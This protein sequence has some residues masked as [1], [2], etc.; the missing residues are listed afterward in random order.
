MFAHTLILSALLL[1]AF[2]P[3]TRKTELA[4]KGVKAGEVQSE[5]PHTVDT[6]S[7][8]G[9]RLGM[10]EGEVRKVVG[11]VD[12]VKKGGLRKAKLV[13]PFQESHDPLLKHE[14][15][16]VV[17]LTLLENTL[18]RMLLQYN[19]LSFDA[20]ES[21][22]ATVLQKA[23]EDETSQYRKGKDL[24]VGRN[25]V[26]IGN[27]AYAD[28]RRLNLRDVKQSTLMISVLPKQI[29]RDKYDAVMV[30]KPKDADF[31]IAQDGRFVNANWV[32]DR[33]VFHLKR[34]PFQLGSN[35]EVMTIALAK[36]RFG[37]YRL[38]LD[39]TEEGR[40][41]C[42]SDM[43][44]GAVTE[45]RNYLFVVNGKLGCNITMCTSAKYNKP[46][47]PLHAYKFSYQFEELF[48]EGASTIK[49]SDFNGTLFGFIAIRKE[50]TNKDGSPQSATVPIEL[51]FQ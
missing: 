34:A 9:L 30:N 2:T 3:Q 21:D 19:P 40:Y 39:P 23:D 16:V 22:L 36:N 47:P 8:G 4:K 11:N 18:V 32:E 25:E 51:V 28:Y 37:E 45:N 42:L 5:T 48:F 14:S 10:S 27:K 35:A 17:E 6:L 38:D 1:G 13:M 12:F 26:W 24:I 49:L 43:R 7:F 20:A 44:C 15:K 50:Q 29:N 46:A 41:S 33:V 31:Y